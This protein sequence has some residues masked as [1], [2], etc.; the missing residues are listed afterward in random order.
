MEP[1]SPARSVTRGSRLKTIAR[2]RW[3]H[4][5]LLLLV[6]VLAYGVLIPWLGY[7][8]DDWPKAWFLHALGPSG[9]HQ[10]YAVDRPYLGWT[11]L[12]TTTLIGESP[13]AWQ[14]FAVVVHG[15]SA[16]ALWWL[17]RVLWPRR[18]D[19]AAIVSLI[20]L[21]FPGFSQHSTALIFSHYFLI[22]AIHVLALGC[23][24]LAVRRP[25]RR[26]VWTLLSLAGSVYSIFSIEYFVGLELVRPLIIFWATRE[27][28][29][30]LR[31]RL[32]QTLRHWL[33]YVPV[34]AGF[35]LWRTYIV[36]F[37][38]YEPGLM[39]RWAEEP[40]RV[41]ALEL[42]RLISQDAIEVTFG[43]WLRLVPLPD[44]QSFGAISFAGYAFLV[45]LVGLLLALYLFHRFGPGRLRGEPGEPDDFNYSRALL[46]TGIWSLCVSGW[47]FWI[48]DLPIQL[49]FPRDRFVLPMMFGA[50]MI[51]TAGLM[52][53]GR[54]S[55]RCRIVALST[56][57]FFIA[58]GVGQQYRYAS[59]YRR[60]WAAQNDFLW[61]LIWRIPDL[62]PG[63]TILVNE[64]PF[65]FD[66]DESMTAAAN[67]I[68]GPEQ[69]AV[70]MPYLVADAKLRLGTVIP[71]FEP[72]MSIVKPYRATAFHGSTS[73]AMVVAYR[74]PRCLRV[75]DLVHHDSLPGIPEPLPRA[76]SLSRPELIRTDSPGE[77]ELPLDVLGAEPP[78]HWCYYF[79][80]A[81]LALQRQD[82]NR[83]VELGEIAFALSDLPNDASERLP[84]I[85]GFARAG[86]WERAV[87]LTLEMVEEQSPTLV[88]ACRTWSRLERETA[89]AADRRVA[90]ERIEQ[91]LSCKAVLE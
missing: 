51:A 9:F 85:E 7:Y 61:Q 39:A 50:A 35:G 49:A 88:T 52:L 30:R 84:F 71:D 16:A 11:Y 72:G 36:G 19:I 76:L 54:G 63:T 80:K 45:V 23:T 14:V 34:L 79:Q 26:F 18:P 37:P 28:D 33:P 65:M 22:L 44:P 6:A 25:A 24:V 90:V 42:L 57:C 40:V 41:S 69:L 10:V 3:F 89:D 59:D 17:L 55:P 48:T 77:Q 53:L 62:E 81:D 2:Q 1:E 32:V 86:L 91:S 43:S 58:F 13:W 21:V 60:D 67:W 78:H 20:F 68:F 38:T 4:P 27:A 8:W 66:D 74:P 31:A 46:I 15:S 73:Q 64:L 82:W 12:I 29:R 56:A 87:A 75:L 70:G 83:I 5:F 47:P